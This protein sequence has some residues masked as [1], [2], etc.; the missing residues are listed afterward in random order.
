MNNVHKMTRISLVN[1]YLF[2]RDDINVN[3]ESIMLTGR[4][5]SGKST[6]LDAIQTIFAGADENKLMFNAASSDG[7]RSGRTIRSYALG[8]VAEANDGPTI[9]EPR[10]VSNTYISL[11]FEDR[12]G[13]PYSF[14]CAFYARKDK[15]HVDKHFFLI[16]GY[17]LSSIDYLKGEYSVLPFKEFEKRLNTLDGKPMICSNPTEFRARTCDLMSAPGSD[18]AISPDVLFKVIKQGL[19]FKPHK[20]VT[21][22][23]RNHILPRRDID[24]VRIE[25]DY[26][27]YHDIQSEI[28]MAKE[29]L[30]LFKAVINHFETYKNKMIKGTSFEWSAAEATVCAADIEHEVTIEK[31]ETLVEKIKAKENEKSLLEARVESLKKHRD[32]ALA[33]MSNSDVTSKVE[34]LKLQKA[35]LAER[36]KPHLNRLSLVRTN[37]ISLETISS[38]SIDEESVQAS[39][40]S[41]LCTLSKETRFEHEDITNSW[42]RDRSNLEQTI[43]KAFALESVYE[44]VKSIYE[45]LTTQNKLID[46]EIESLA[47]IHKRLS[48]GKA[49][50][51]RQTLR[52]IDI[53]EEHGFT[54][55]PICDL[56]E[57]SDEHWQKGIER[58]LGAWNREALLIVDDNGEAVN[59]SL[60]EQAL[61]IYR[62]E[63]KTDK[64][65]RSV[66]IL[67]P[68]RIR[69]Q[70]HPPEHGTAG[71]LIVS[72]NPIV[73]DYLQGLLHQVQLVNTELELRQ[74]KRAITPDGMVAA[75]GS[76]SG[77]NKIQFVLFGIKARKDQAENLH[78][79]LTEL[80]VNK[81]DLSAR[82]TKYANVSQTLSANIQAIKQN[83]D[84]ILDSFDQRIV[85]E[86]ELEVNHQSLQALNQNSDYTDLKKHFDEAD[87]IFSE[88]LN[89][90][91]ALSVKIATEK[92]TQ[93]QYETI[94]LQL[95]AKVTQAGIDRKALEDKQFFFTELASETFEQLSEAHV[96]DYSAIEQIASQKAK[97]R[98]GSA[99]RSKEEGSK[100]LV[101]L[102]SLH[103]LEDKDELVEL[104]PLAALDRCKEYATAIEKSEITI[105]EEDA[106][107]AR[108]MMLQH[109]RSEI[110]SKL[111]DNINNLVDT[112]KVL[113]SSLQDL[114]FNNS[115]YK[116]THR[117][118]EIESLREVYDYVMLPDD[119][120]T[121]GGLF[122][123]SKEHPGLKVIEQVVTDG[124][125]SEIADY[126]NFFSYDIITT[127]TETG[128]R[129]NFS[130]LLS[131]GSGGEQQSPF[132]VALGASFMSAYKLHKYGNKAVLGGAA[133]A[134]FDEA[135]SK[136]D[137]KN[138]A[139]ALEFFNSLGLQII[140][141]APPEASIKISPYV[142]KTVTVIRSGTT[143]FLDDHKYSEEAIDLL[144]SDNPM[145]H[146]ELA[147]KYLPSV[148][149]EFG[150]E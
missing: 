113:N 140:L 149:E 4:N 86:E 41:A 147:D 82:H 97:D 75:N 17:D 66:K 131:V 59:S 22:F 20:D 36:I 125:L 127:D 5:G 30:E 24:V 137:G 138:T 136:M 70:N 95:K 15:T 129:R 133:V 120:D 42:P 79:R 148:K 118:S 87:R 50:L 142:D 90:V 81:N 85:I 105:H 25:N 83:K 145:I 2:T 61:A 40:D 121:S 18:G 109:F 96:D 108:E 77:G 78:R 3:G 124:R 62:R 10:A 12:H 60:L 100:K 46:D 44:S 11:T 139:A 49:S 33:L 89:S 107:Q 48:E 74:S 110:A 27:N 69:A 134:I 144:N 91:S 116:F 84:A 65:L 58:F 122:D 32:D 1:W 57:V 56:A 123:D 63:K 34:N 23:T 26:K 43:N 73:L 111:K 98:F 67:N 92:V 13:N 141:A 126:R 7:T 117:L 119:V 128:V 28:E 132:Y 103:D 38:N 76:I 99:Y 19:T 93:S 64:D 9:A 14:G 94:L 104:Q 72:E 114:L 6:I 54:A 53:Y 135:M 115:K 47:L 35:N 16:K 101:E 146:P 106:K 55:L 52:M 130:E 71:S 68:E 21:E 143:V 80:L 150:I 51:M 45:D 102:V 29:R 112:F 31:L 8:E 88:Q 39:L 37:L